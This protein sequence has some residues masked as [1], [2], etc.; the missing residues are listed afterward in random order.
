LP[1]DASALISHPS[2]RPYELRHNM[3][4]FLNEMKSGG[5]RPERG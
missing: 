4:F 5:H 2:A 3:R 1:F